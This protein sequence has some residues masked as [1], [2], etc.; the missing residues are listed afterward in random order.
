MGY[1][2]QATNVLRILT[3]RGL[4]DRERDWSLTPATGGLNSHVFFARPEGANQPVFTVRLGTQIPAEIQGLADAAG[5]PGVPE[6]RLQT[7]ILLVHDFAPGTPRDLVDLDE[8]QLE[9]LVRS[10][11]CIHARHISGFTPWP[12]TG[13]QRGAR[14]DLFRFRVS[15][16]SNYAC[17]AGVRGG[18]QH[19]ELARLLQGLS[20]LDL[21]APSWAAQTFSRLHGDLSRG[22]LLWH[23]HDLTLIDWEYSRAGDPAE[24][25]AYLL[26]EGDAGFDLAA[27]LAADYRNLG[28]EP[29]IQSR[30]GIY[31]IFT[32]IDSALWWIDYGER[33][34]NR[35]D[36]QIGRRIETADRWCRRLAEG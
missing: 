19:P 14:A 20:D 12:R 17:F 31:A 24:D 2:V 4:I 27:L 1:V 26:T 35:D 30:L 13:L 3:E 21:A 5:C 15:S 6:L 8:R 36:E 28:G 18:G 7:P 29:G 16:L 23:G 32:A 25:L 33:H 22:N 11:A 34:G 10:L 9:A